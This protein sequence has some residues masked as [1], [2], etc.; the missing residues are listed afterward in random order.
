MPPW[1]P[2]PEVRRAA[3]RGLELRAEQPPSNRAGTA[4]GLA[5]ARDLSAGRPV[6]ADVIRRMVSFF[7]RHEVN[8]DTRRE[9][10][11]SRAMQ[12]WLLWGG[13][14]GRRWAE[15]IAREYDL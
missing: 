5:R 2:P 9:D 13:T 7:A 12:A 1:T 10:P 4:V 8:A 11:N 14:P 6:S 15:R 3:E